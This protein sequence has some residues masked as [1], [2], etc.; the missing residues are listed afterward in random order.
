MLLLHRELQSITVQTAT[1]TD[2][3]LHYDYLVLSTGLQYAIE[4]PKYGH[5]PEN[6]LVILNEDNCTEIMEKT[7]QE[8]VDGKTNTIIIIMIENNRKHS[9]V[10]IRFN[11]LFCHSSF[12]E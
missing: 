5:I 2:T 10:W 3:I 8:Y 12:A 6:G 1:S 11:Q 9:S 7:Q 4:M